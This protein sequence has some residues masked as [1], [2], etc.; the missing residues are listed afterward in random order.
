[1]RAGDH[2]R[3]DCRC[4][5]RTCCCAHEVERTRARG[6][7]KSA[8]PRGRRRPN[9]RYAPRVGSRRRAPLRSKWAM[10]VIVAAPFGCALV[11]P[12]ADY[13]SATCDG[14]AGAPGATAGAAGTMSA[15]AEADVATGGAGGKSGSGGANGG[16]AGSPGGGHAGTAALG[17]GG[18]GA[19]GGNS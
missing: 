3:E 9:F 11:A 14:C 1:M 2:R 7:E 8:I 12:I 5:E 16:H 6:G 18:G 15:D 4:D 10:A 19:E 13:D 17:V